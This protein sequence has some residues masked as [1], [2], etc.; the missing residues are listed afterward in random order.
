VATQTRSN[1]S[2]IPSFIKKSINLNVITAGWHGYTL[3]QNA[4]NLSSVRKSGQEANYVV[5][6]TVHNLLHLSYDTTQLRRLWTFHAFQQQTGL[7]DTL[8]SMTKQS[9]H[10][11]NIKCV[12]G[13]TLVSYPE[14][15]GFKTRQGYWP[16]E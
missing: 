2:L 3:I 13:S 7:F 12:L 5:L 16:Y 15:H 4:I 9:T 8:P 11:P 6:K 1:E 10:L 14:G